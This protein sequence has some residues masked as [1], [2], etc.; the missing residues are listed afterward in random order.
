MAAPNIVNTS[1]IY[2]KTTGILLTSTSSD[3]LVNPSNS[4][5]VLKINSLYLSNNTTIS[6]T[7]TISWN[8]GTT[9]FILIK[10]VVIPSNSVLVLIDK[11]APL[12]LEENYKLIGISDA[13][14]NLFI[15]ATISYEEIS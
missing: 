8:N 7:A 15:N 4:G 6:V 9:S 13:D 1:I 12:Y 3:L 2:G 14:G 10:D 5:K 11:N